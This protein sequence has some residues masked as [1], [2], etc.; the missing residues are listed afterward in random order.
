MTSRTPRFA[1]LNLNFTQYVLDFFLSGKFIENIGWR[2]SI[3]IQYVTS[4]VA[5]EILE[6]RNSFGLSST[7]R[8]RHFHRG[9]DQIGQITLKSEDLQYLCKKQKCS[10]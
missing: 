2:R 8:S 10:A 4:L 5:Y 3:D 6:A 7:N 9:T 1:T